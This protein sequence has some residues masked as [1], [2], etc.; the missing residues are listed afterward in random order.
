MNRSEVH[1]LHVPYAQR[2]MRRFEDHLA[3]CRRERL[4]REAGQAQRQLELAAVED[5]GGDV[6]RAALVAEGGAASP[7]T[8]APP[9]GPA[10]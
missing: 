5:A 3:A 8:P 10:A 1:D 6:E 9:G 7:D 2:V 4:A